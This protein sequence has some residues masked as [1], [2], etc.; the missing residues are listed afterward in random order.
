[1]LERF[2]PAARQALA[3]ARD[4]ARRAG[5]D[6]IC[7]EHL[8]L[9]L[10]SEP[11]AAADSLGAA[12]LTADELR[13]RVPRGSNAD[14]GS[15][16][17]ADALASLGIDL[18]TVR[19]ATDAAFGRGAL[20]RVRVPGRR[21]LPMADDTKRTLAG[22]VREAHKHGRHEITSGHLLIG[23]LDQPRN[24]ALA[25]LDATGTDLRALRADIGRRITEPAG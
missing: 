11:G 10:L 2:E 1:M 4:E 22:A 6:R 19:R 5:Q 16:L 7:T 12:G 21:R 17:D 3:D 15:P 23:I 13:P 9:G 18:D 8:L 14:P 25:L 24:G 20:D